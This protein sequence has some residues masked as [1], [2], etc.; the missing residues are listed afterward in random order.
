M[1]TLTLF[2]L[3]L[4]LIVLCL[5][6]CMILIQ[7]PTNRFEQDPYKLYVPKAEQSVYGHSGK[8]IFSDAVGLSLSRLLEQL[9]DTFPVD[10]FTTESRSTSRVETTRQL[11]GEWWT[12][13]SLEGKIEGIGLC[14]SGGGVQSMMY[15]VGLLR[16]LNSAKVLNNQ[17]ISHI[18]AT[19]GSA[20]CLTPVSFIPAFKY[21]YNLESLVGSYKCPSEYTMEEMEFV[22]RAPYLGSLVKNTT[23]VKNL[24][25]AF[26][27]LMSENKNIPID[28]VM[29]EAYAH[30]VLKP[31]DMYY[32]YAPVQINR[33]TVND[34]HL[35]IV[36]GFKQY[37]NAFYLRP[38]FPMPHIMLTSMDTI[39]WK[40]FKYFP[41]EMTPNR[42]GCLCDDIE[43][44]NIP[45][46]GQCSN[47]CFGG[48]ETFGNVPS[49]PNEPELISTYIDNIYNI[50]GINKYIGWCSGVTNAYRVRS[51]KLRKL[52]PKVKI[53]FPNSNEDITAIDYLAD[54][55]FYDNSG[56]CSLYARQIKHIII[57]LHDGE[58]NPDYENKSKGTYPISLQQQ[59]GV[60]YG[61]ISHYGRGFLK[62]DDSFSNFWEVVHILDEKKK[63]KEIGLFTKTYKTNNIE[64]SGITEY[65]VTIT[66]MYPHNFNEY[67]YKYNIDIQN[68]MEVPHKINY[69]FK[70]ALYENNITPNF[71]LNAY[72][73]IT[74]YIAYNYLSKIIRN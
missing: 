63:N 44:F 46:G 16:G 19:S 35:Q 26:E 68:Q 71:Y 53:N 54:G 60:E 36:E 50:V 69:L 21:I 4:L 47:F 37:N 61:E 28:E 9:H 27:Q 56:A 6:F 1:E 20:W 64:E 29:S 25:K 70:P 52:V 7:K 3:F 23:I 73:N 30:W 65:D 57:C 24:D 62:D 2:L 48:I 33:E 17:Y 67:I 38:D 31:L 18:T 32:T 58:L 34:V 15:A 41:L 51:D 8:S 59:F 43:W 40:E 66:W 11:F 5:S 55:S 45:L 12:G 72:A 49:K 22:P 74:A 14:L 39:N 10:S 13:K 42:I